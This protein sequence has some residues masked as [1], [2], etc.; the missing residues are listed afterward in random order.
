[1]APRTSEALR[2][3]YCWTTARMLFFDLLVF[4]LRNAL[5]K[6]PA[7]EPGLPGGWEAD[8]SRVYL[9]E[10]LGEKCTCLLGFKRV[11]LRPGES[12]NVNIFA[13]ARFDGSAGEWR[14]AGGAHR[15]ALIQAADDLI[16]T[17]ETSLPE[18]LFGR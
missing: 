1:M 18:R 6:G 3:S 11:E 14:I 10:T 17:A 5:R 12:T 2:T 7:P 16:M 8:F 9:T 15:I 4:V 13:V